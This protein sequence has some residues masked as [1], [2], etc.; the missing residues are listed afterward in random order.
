[1]DSAGTKVS[2]AGIEVV[3][4]AV[5]TVVGGGVVGAIVE[6]VTGVLVGMFV[7]VLSPQAT[8]KR[9]KVTTPI[10]PHHFNLDI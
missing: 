9:S 10:I 4:A 3:G 5:V 7:T 2:V 1:M 6:V 8:S